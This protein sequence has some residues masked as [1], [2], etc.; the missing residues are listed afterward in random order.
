M[1][2]N[3][4]HEALTADER[5]ELFALRKRVAKLETEREILKKFAAFCASENE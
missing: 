5:E 3:G 1:P 4:Q 2:D